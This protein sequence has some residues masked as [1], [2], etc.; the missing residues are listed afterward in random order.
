LFLSE[1]SKKYNPNKYDE[2]YCFCI[3]SIQE[4]IKEISDEMEKIHYRMQYNDNLWFGSS[5]RAY[6]FHNSKIRLNTK[7]NNLEG[8]WKLLMSLMCIIDK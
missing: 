4:S 8:R 6:K 5:I 2:T 3:T 7:L 1:L